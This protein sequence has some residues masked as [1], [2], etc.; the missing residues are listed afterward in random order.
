[1]QMKTILGILLALCFVMSVTAVAAPA[2]SANKTEKT[3]VKSVP[4]PVT[5]LTAVFAS[6]H[7]GKTPLTVTFTD[8]STG[9]P[10]MWSWNFGDKSL[11]VKTKDVTHTYIKAG[12]YTVKLTVMNAKGQ[13]STASK[14]LTL[15]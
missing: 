7:H 2:T 6:T 15:P 1:M 9:L 5:K 10:T 12:K 11:I 14:I 13:I 3:T 4:T 8:K